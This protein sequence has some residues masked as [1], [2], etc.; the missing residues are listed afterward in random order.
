LGLNEIKKIIKENDTKLYEYISQYGEEVSK[1]N[2]TLHQIER[3]KRN[4]QVLIN[5]L[6]EAGN[7]SINNFSLHFIIILSNGLI[8][9]F[10]H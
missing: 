2:V 1:N 8:K 10:P 6:N 7:Q 9:Y 5:V 3:L 4:Y